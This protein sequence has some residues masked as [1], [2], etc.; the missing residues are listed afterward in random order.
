MTPS[1]DKMLNLFLAFVALP[2]T[3]A[4]SKPHIVLIV[5]DD[6]GW[7]DVGFTGSGSNIRTPTLDALA[8]SGVVLHNY[9]V[10]P[11]CTPTRNCL[12]S[13]RYPIHTGLQHSVILDSLP[14]G[15]PLNETV[16]ASVMKKAGYAT[17]MAR[18]IKLS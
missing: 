13:G 3:F 5:A 16:I 10:S 7:N 9:Y 15:L 1:R 2:A 14:N 17:H 11:I 4:A 6:L 12:M 8:K 18:R